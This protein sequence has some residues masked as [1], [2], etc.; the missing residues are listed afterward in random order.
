[1]KNLFVLLLAML[2][3]AF[4]SKFTSPVKAQIVKTLTIS[5]AD[6]TLVNADTATVSLPVVSNSVSATA[7]LEKVSGTVAGK[8]Y[9][10]ASVDG[11]TYDRLDSLTLAN[12]AT[13]NKTFN[14]RSSN[15]HLIY[16]S[17]RLSFITSGTQASKPKAYATRRED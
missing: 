14:L 8:I 6:D 1:M 17:Y 2:T 13:N 5:A 11:S 3:I 9:L 7:N 16:A 15:G 12:V 4:T 10:E